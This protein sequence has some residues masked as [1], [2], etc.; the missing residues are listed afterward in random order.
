MNIIKNRSILEKLDYGDHICYLY[1]DFY[2]YR[3]VAI[4]YILDGLSNNEKLLCVVS[5]YSKELLIQDLQNNNCDT[6]YLIK[7]GQLVI[8][9]NKNVY[10]KSE[11][12]QVHGTIEYWKQELKRV[13]KER[14]S[15]FRVMGEID[16]AL[17]QTLEGIHRLM[18]YELWSKNELITWRIM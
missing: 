11:D 2:D 16:N 9:S 12:F 5:D 3:E 13:K 7:T 18:E 6:N 14:Y 15:G 8:T 17:A 10:S 4:N 1:D